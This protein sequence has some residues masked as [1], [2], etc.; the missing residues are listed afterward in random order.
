MGAQEFSLQLPWAA[1][2]AHA[3]PGDLTWHNLPAAQ[4]DAFAGVAVADGMP[5]PRKDTLFRVHKGQSAHTGGGIPH[6]HACPPLGGSGIPDRGQD[7]AALFSAADIDNLCGASPG[8]FQRFLHSVIVFR[9]DLSSGSRVSRLQSRCLCRVTVLPPGL[10]ISEKP[11]ISAPSENILTPNGV[12]QT[13]TCARSVTTVRIFLM[14]SH[15]P[16]DRVVW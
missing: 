15:P 1:H 7:G 11:T 13:V 14:G 2:S 3:A 12:P 4:S 9:P 6:P 5:Q 8:G 16:S 10:S